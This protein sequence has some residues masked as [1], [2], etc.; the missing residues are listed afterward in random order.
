MRIFC[1]LRAILKRRILKKKNFP[2]S[3]ILNVK[4]FLESMILNEKIFAKAWFWNKSFS[5][6]Q[7]WNQIFYNASDFEL[8]I[9]RRDSFSRKN[10][11]L[12][13]MNL[14]KKIFL[15]NTILKKK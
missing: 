14:K 5:S 11:F 7:I 8:K 4:F 2:R 13:S 6:W 1:V 3:M 9:L 12:E 15:K 10:I